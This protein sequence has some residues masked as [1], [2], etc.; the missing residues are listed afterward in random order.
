MDFKDVDARDKP[1]HYDEEI[2]V[3]QENGYVRP[4]RTRLTPSAIPTAMVAVIP[5]TRNGLTVRGMERPMAWLMRASTK[6]AHSISSSI[7]LPPS[8]S[9]S[10]KPAMKSAA[11]SARLPCRRIACSSCWLPPSPSDCRLRRRASA[12]VSASAICMTIRIPAVRAEIK[13]GVNGMGVA[14]WYARPGLSL[15]PAKGTISYQRLNLRYA[16]VPRKENLRHG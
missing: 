16:N 13:G 7:R 4:M 5:M 2:F 14:P 6:T 15:H 8:I 9:I 3:A 10:V 12:T 11:F 1:G